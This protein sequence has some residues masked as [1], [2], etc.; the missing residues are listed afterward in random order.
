MKSYSRYI[1]CRFDL[2]FFFFFS[3]ALIIDRRICSLELFFANATRV[4]KVFRD[5]LANSNMLRL[6]PVEL[7]AHCNVPRRFCII[8]RLYS[9]TRA[10]DGRSLGGLNAWRPGLFVRMYINAARWRR[11]RN[12]RAH[13]REFRRAVSRNPIKERNPGELQG[14]LTTPAPIRSSFLGPFPFPRLSNEEPRIPL[15]QNSNDSPAITARDYPLSFLT[16]FVSSERKRVKERERG[17]GKRRESL[18]GLSRGSTGK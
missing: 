9:N 15:G 3:T 18:R 5:S 11:T 1:A 12:K 10:F 14:P 13:A 16:L 8:R 4:A 7:L 6:S 2:F 17:G